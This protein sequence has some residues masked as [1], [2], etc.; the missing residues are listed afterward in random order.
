MKQI[1]KLFG[2]TDW[3][4]TDIEWLRYD[5]ERSLALKDIHDARALRGYGDFDLVAY[6]RNGSHPPDIKESKALTSDHVTE[7]KASSIG[8][9]LQST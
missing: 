2:T 9:P 1:Q 7:P 6:I 5:R 4:N 8:E 3:P